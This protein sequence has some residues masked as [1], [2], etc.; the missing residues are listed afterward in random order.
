MGSS[1]FQ[2]AG[3]ILRKERDNRGAKQREQDLLRDE[4]E[5]RSGENIVNLKV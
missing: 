1:V 4:G 5:Q 3:G 2:T